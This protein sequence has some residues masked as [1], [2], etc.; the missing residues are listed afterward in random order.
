MPNVVGPITAWYYCKHGVPDGFRVGIQTISD[1]YDTENVH[2]AD[3]HRSCCSRCLSLGMG[4]GSLRVRGQAH[5]KT[6]DSESLHLYSRFPSAVPSSSLSAGVA[7]GQVRLA[8]ARHTKVL[9]RHNNRRRVVHLRRIALTLEER[10]RI[11]GR[12]NKLDSRA[13]ENQIPRSSR[14][15]Y[16]RYEIAACV[17]F[18]RAIKFSAPRPAPPRP[19]P[20]TRRRVFPCSPLR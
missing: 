9:Y 17:F 15:R 20:R 4:P 16:A 8:C 1:T 18:A 7:D 2:S 10:G 11:F 3:R 13:T 6:T 19:P 5:K 12:F 14:Y